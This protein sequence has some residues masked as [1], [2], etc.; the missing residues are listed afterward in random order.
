M[1]RIELLRI[2]ANRLAV[3]LPLLRYFLF[4]TGYCSTMDI[5]SPPIYLADTVETCF[6]FFFFFFQ[7]AAKFLKAQRCQ[8]TINYH[9]SSTRHINCIINS[10]NHVKVTACIFAQHLI[11]RF[12]PLSV[13]FSLTYR[14]YSNKRPTSN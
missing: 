7:L 13:K 6:F 10:T 5:S 14:I 9:P 12:R 11:H 2:N 4:S 8:Q 3:K 1:K